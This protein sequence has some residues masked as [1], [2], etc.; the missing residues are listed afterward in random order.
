MESNEKTQ[1]F[2]P[3]GIENIKKRGDKLADRF[4]PSLNRAKSRKISYK[5][6]QKKIYI[7]GKYLGWRKKFIL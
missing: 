6:K 7:Y 5:T 4:R 3:D 1:S 2:I